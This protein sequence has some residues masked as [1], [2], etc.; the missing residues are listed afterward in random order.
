VK[1]EYGCFVKRKE[2]DT[3][4]LK[5]GGIVSLLVLNGTMFPASTESIFRVLAGTVV[6]FFTVSFCGGSESCPV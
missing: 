6:R 1:L 3:K 2:S 4:E 5:A